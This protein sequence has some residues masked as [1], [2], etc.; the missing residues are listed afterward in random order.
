ML[1]VLAVTTAFGADEITIKGEGKCGKCGLKETEKCQNVVEVTKD[2]KKTK[3]YFVQN[4][5]SKKFHENV[6][7]ATAKVKATGTAKKVDGKMEFT[8]TKI[9]LDK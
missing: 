7:Q 6:C 4:D 2:G 3:Y 9:E 5:V 8:A 1:A